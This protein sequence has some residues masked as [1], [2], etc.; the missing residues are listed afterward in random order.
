MLLVC[1][2]ASI[3]TRRCKSS[4]LA[5][6]IGRWWVQGLHAIVHV[7]A[8]TGGV[9]LRFS[10]RLLKC[11]NCLRFCWC[12]LFFFQGLGHASAK[13]SF[14]REI[15]FAIHSIAF[16]VEFRSVPFPSLPTSHF[17]CNASESMVS[18]VMCFNI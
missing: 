7:R 11:G 5:T 6:P 2:F 18:S 17:R 3:A 13:C 12:G 10:P 15:W 1:R 14:S 16:G 9:S 8:L 4:K